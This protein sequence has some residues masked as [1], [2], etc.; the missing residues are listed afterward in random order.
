MKNKRKLLFAFIFFINTLIFANDTR[1]ILGSSVG[2]ADNKRT[3]ITMHQET[4]NMRL[5]RDYYDVDVTFEFINTGETET[6]S[7]GFPV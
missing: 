4:I 7:L 2:V 3:N 1:I 5:Y 6:I